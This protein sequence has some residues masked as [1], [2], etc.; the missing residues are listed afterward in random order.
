[1]QAIQVIKSSGTWKRCHV[2]DGSVIV[3]SYATADYGPTA[4]LAP[5]TGE[6]AVRVVTGGVHSLSH[7]L[8]GPRQEVEVELA[9][10]GMTHLLHNLGAHL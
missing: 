9:R 2:G 7:W 5:E 6:I 10:I 4:P 1:M 8:V 3:P